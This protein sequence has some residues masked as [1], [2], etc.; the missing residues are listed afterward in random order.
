M[1]YFV[2]QRTSPRLP[3]PAK[4]Y[5]TRQRAR[6]PLA[7]EKWFGPNLILF[8]QTLQQS[9]SNNFFLIVQWDGLYRLTFPEEYRH[10]FLVLFLFW[11]NWRSSTIFSFTYF[12]RQ[13]I[14]IQFWIRVMF[15]G[16]SMSATISKKHILTLKSHIWH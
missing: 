14:R 10:F 11:K 6:T 13:N 5:Y 7:L 16:L 12:D 3:H 8:M 4:K 1:P 2:L 9:V 15:Q